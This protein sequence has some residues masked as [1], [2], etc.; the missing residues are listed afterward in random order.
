MLLLDHRRDVR[1]RLEHVAVLVA[2]RGSKQFVGDVPNG[3][4]ADDIRGAEAR[5]LRVAP[6]ARR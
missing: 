2:G 4:E 5:A 3:V 1:G 6:S